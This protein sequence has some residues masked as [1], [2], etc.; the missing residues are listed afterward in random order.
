[1]RFHE[2]ARP[3]ALLDVWSFLQRTCSDGFLAA[4]EDRRLVGYALFVPSLRAVQ[5]RA[6][7]S[8]AAFTWALRA[9]LGHYDMRP[10]RL[11]RTLQNKVY[12]LAHGRRFRTC[13]DAQLLNI[14]VDPSRQGHGIA[15]RLIDAGLQGLR[16]ARVPEVRLEVRPA[17]APAIALYRKTG[18]REVGRTRDLEGEWIVMVA[19]P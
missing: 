4:R 3:N 2:N 1:M 16:A 11:V 13:G 17:N 9:V 8:G 10:G 15:R 7:V 12:F 5:R 6:V 18:W 14:A 19:N